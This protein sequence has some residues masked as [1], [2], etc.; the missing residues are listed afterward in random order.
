M[1]FLSPD[2]DA[3]WE[4]I[5][6]SKIGIPMKPNLDGWRFVFF[7]ENGTPITGKMEVERKTDGSFYQLKFDLPSYIGIP[8]L[9]PDNTIN[10]MVL[11]DNKTAL[12]F[13]K[14]ME[15]FPND[16]KPKNAKEFLGIVRNTKLNSSID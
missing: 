10:L 15:P 7:N 8:V 13:N 3:S 2:E 9:T 5:E 4:Y 6:I 14:T 1:A 12:N 11:I 16:E